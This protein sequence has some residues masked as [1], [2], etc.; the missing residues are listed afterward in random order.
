M[1]GT[2]ART[3]MDRLLDRMVQRLVWVVAPREV[4]LFGSYGKG[5]ANRASDLDLLVITDQPADAVVVDAAF[6]ATR[7]AVKCDVVLRDPA[8]LAIELRD[9]YG[10]LAGVLAGGRSLYRRPGVP[11]RLPR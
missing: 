7:S 6:D 4:I 11:E 8:S 9:P 1:T 3:G 2:V 5:L 10:F